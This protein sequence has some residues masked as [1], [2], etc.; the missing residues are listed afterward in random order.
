MAVC[1]RQ[2][3]LTIGFTTQKEHPHHQQHKEM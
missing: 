2:L 3:P 1:G